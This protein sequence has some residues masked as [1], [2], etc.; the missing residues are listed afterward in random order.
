MH[1]PMSMVMQQLTCGS[2]KT[3]CWELGFFLLPNWF[4]GLNSGCHTWQWVLSPFNRLTG[5]GLLIQSWIQCR[6]TGCTCN[7]EQP[8]PWLFSRASPSPQQSSV[9]IPPSLTPTQV[10]PVLLCSRLIPD[11]T[12]QRVPPLSL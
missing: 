12:Q 9:H 10:T 1:K 8:S 5:P 11:A 4:L 7:I 2:Q 3:T 6:D